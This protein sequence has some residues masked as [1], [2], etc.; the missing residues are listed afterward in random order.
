M[1]DNRAAGIATLLVLTHALCRRKD[2]EGQACEAPAAGARIINCGGGSEDSRARSLHG[3]MAKADYVV[4]IT[5]L[6][7][8]GCEWLSAVLF[9][10]CADAVLSACAW[11]YAEK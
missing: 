9:G 5:D 2:L 7:Y 8:L 10:R 1:Q 4:W 3:P 11:G 6:W